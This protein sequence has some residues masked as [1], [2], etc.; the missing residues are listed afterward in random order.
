M[1]YYFGIDNVICTT[2]NDNYNEAIPLKERIEKINNLFDE[3][4]EIYYISSRESE[5]ENGVKNTLLTHTQFEE[6]KCKY[7]KIYLT[8]S[9]EGTYVDN[10]NMTPDTFFK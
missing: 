1:K 6:W 9:I 10:R 5:G 3:G 2:E 8:N 7:T 4:D